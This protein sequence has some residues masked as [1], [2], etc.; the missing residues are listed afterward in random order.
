MNWDARKARVRVAE[1]LAVMALYF[2]AGQA[3]RLTPANHGHSSPVWLAAG[4]AFAALLLRG[5]YLGVGVAAGSFLVNVVGHAPLLTAAGVGHSRREACARA[6]NRKIG[7]ADALT[8]EALA[9]Q[10]Y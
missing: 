6:E 10:Y 5:R 4:I 7:W 2:V 9:K 8:L 3:G 1:S